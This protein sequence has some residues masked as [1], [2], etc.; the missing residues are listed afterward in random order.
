ME[1]NNLP[2]GINLSFF[3]QVEGWQCD[4]CGFTTSQRERLANHLSSQH[5]R[6]DVQK[7]EIKSQTLRDVEKTCRI[8]KMTSILKPPVKKVENIAKY[9]TGG[10]SMLPSSDPSK[11]KLGQHSNVRD[12][13]SQPSNVKTL[14]NVGMLPPLQDLTKRNIS[15]NPARAAA[16]NLR[17]STAAPLNMIGG[18]NKNLVKATMK[19][20]PGIAPSM[21][22]TRFQPIIS[23]AGNLFTTDASPEVI[24]TLDTLMVNESDN[25][26]GLRLQHMV[27]GEVKSE[28]KSSTTRNENRQDMYWCGICGNMYEREETLMMHVKSHTTIQRLP[29]FWPN[30]N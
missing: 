30:N 12:L 24:E 14:A 20:Q 5:N 21:L 9:E 17:E 19:K 10:G 16:L 28:A 25:D 1:V 11:Q 18:T 22:G 27:D 13:S 7:T 15:N 6:S 23:F 26:K 3:V 29:K 4:L 2:L 8:T